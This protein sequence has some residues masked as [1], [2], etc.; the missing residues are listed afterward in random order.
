VGANLQ[1][2][3]ASGRVQAASGAALAIGAANFEVS[4]AGRHG[5]CFDRNRIIRARIAREWIAA[6]V[7]VE[8]CAAAEVFTGCGNAVQNLDLQRR[9]GL[10]AGGAHRGYGAHAVAANA[11]RGATSPVR[12]EA[13]QM[14]DGPAL[15]AACVGIG[16]AVEGGATCS[17]YTGA[18]AAD[19]TLATVS[20]DIAAPLARVAIDAQVLVQGRTAHLAGAAA[21]IC[22]QAAL[23]GGTKSGTAHLR[24][25]ACAIVV[26]L[27]ALRA[28][29]GHHA[30]P[31]TAQL[32]GIAFEV[33]APILQTDPAHAGT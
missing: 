9:I 27:A 17:G 15:P 31:V 32:V 2:D 11:L 24:Q 4:E 12:E 1:A 16:G 28:N 3:A 20:M 26:H 23:A 29:F 8:Y 14:V 10:Q 13:A 6:P 7:I 19:L 21:G 5:L 22:L 25:V 33:D 30:L 18:V